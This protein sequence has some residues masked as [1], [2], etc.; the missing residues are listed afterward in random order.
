MAGGENIGKDTG[1]LYLGKTNF[2]TCTALSTA[3]GLIV[4]SNNTSGSK[5]ANANF[6]LSNVIYCD[7]GLAVPQTE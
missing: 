3:P 7:G 4:G 1:T 5:T 6:G 2:I